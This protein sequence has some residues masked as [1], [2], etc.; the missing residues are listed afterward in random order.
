MAESA[1]EFL[2]ERIVILLE[3]EGSLL[4]GLRQE[5]K[6]IKRELEGMRSFLKDADRIIRRENNNLDGVKT[7]V[8]EVRDSAYDVEDVIDEFMYHLGCQR[9]SIGFMGIFHKTIHFPKDLLMRHKIATKL[10][11]IKTQVHA[12]SQR[13]QRY[14]FDHMKNGTFGSHFS[15]EWLQHHGES[16]FFIEDDDIVGIEKDSELLLGWLLEPELRRTVVSVFGMGGSGKTTLVAKIYRSQ[17]VKRYFDC[18][19]WITVSQTYKIEDLFRNMIKDFFDSNKGGVPVDLSTM[20]YRGLVQ[21]I[22]DYLQQK[23]YVIV[24]DDVWSLNL[25]REISVALPDGGTGSRVMLTTRKEDIATFSFGAE[26]HV[27]RLLPLKEKEAWILFCRK[28]LSLDPDR[29]CC[30]PEL[31]EVSRL[32]LEK[33]YLEWKKVYD[34]LNWELSNNPFLEVVKGILFL[35]YNDLPYYLKHCF[36]YCCIFPEDFRIKRKRLIRLWIAEGFVGERRGMTMEEVADTYLIELISRSM[37]QVVEK[38]SFG[39]PKNCG[40]HDLMREL[41]VWVSEEENFCKIYDESSYNIEAARRDICIAPRRLSIHK[42]HTDAGIHSGINIAQLRS[43]FMFVGNVHDSSSPTFSVKSILP[44]GFKLLRV[45]DLQDIPI[46]SV[47][48]ELVKLFNLRYLNL[49]NTQVK[50][51]PNSI[52]ELRN[53]QTL[54]IRD[55]KIEALP[56]GILKCKNLRHVTMFRFIRS[57]I[58]DY[59]YLN[60]NQV[61]VDIW[62]LKN[63]QVLAC[64]VAKD[65]II[66]QLGGMTQLKSIG[67]TNVREVDEIDL[68]KTIEKLKLLRN[69]FILVT[70]ED[71]SLRMD[72]LFSAPPLLKTLL[73][74]GKLEKVPLWFG[75]LRN[76]TSLTLHWSRLSEDPLPLF[77]E[78]SCLAYLYLDNA[79]DGQLL[80]IHKGWFLKLKCL[81]L[82]R[83][84]RLNEVIIEKGALPNLEK[85]HLVKS[86]EL[87][88]VP[89]GIEYLTNLHTLI[90]RNMPDELALRLRGEDSIDRP[91]VR[92]IPKID[93]WKYTPGFGWA[94]ESLA[95]SSSDHRN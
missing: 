8:Q 33:T 62:K 89:L 43:L 45:L 79:Y 38:N 66:K 25:W 28:A 16:S 64:I 4:G 77:C 49:R 74:V 27:H 12:I 1:V 13:S 18:Y 61:P 54:D 91:R 80:C 56:N 46:M 58:D 24:L 63:L 42:V 2:L 17:I 75:S 59:T 11:V 6:E 19:A 44:S 3:Y 53:L 26:G 69:L 72:S 15:T 84:S 21:T 23:R 83:F 65:D 87:K 78:L 40:M 82:S 88:M 52:G 81:T 34:S 32:I 92:H 9:R 37:L 85:L 95:S 31:E 48:D 50:E 29:Q 51:L 73:M 76:L 20:N 93:Y 47:P 5:F 22:V 36:R 70:N 14:G 55:S 10:Q 35:S 30:P 90:L 39:R 86:K 67:I 94:T 60:G 71:E 68:C 57:R 7:W 41:A